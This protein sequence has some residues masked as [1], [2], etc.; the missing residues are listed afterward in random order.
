MSLLSFEPTLELSSSDVDVDVDDED[1]DVESEAVES[2]STVPESLPEDSD[3]PDDS[4]PSTELVVL[5]DSPDARS[6]CRRGK[7]PMHRTTG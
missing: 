2:S 7:A 1:V 3:S 4:E 6:H 5:E